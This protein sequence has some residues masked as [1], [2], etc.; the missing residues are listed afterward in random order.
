MLK[1]ISSQC[2]VTLVL[3]LSMFTVACDATSEFGDETI[4]NFNGSFISESSDR[5]GCFEFVFPL[6]LTLSDGTTLDIDSKDALRTTI[7]NVRLES[8]DNAKPDFVFPLSVIVDEETIELATLQELQELKSNCRSSRVTQGGKGNR[9]K[10]TRTQ[11]FSIVYPVSFSFED[12]SSVSVESRDEL[13]EAFRVFKEEN[14]DATERPS[15]VYPI[16]VTLEDGESIEVADEAAYNELIESC[17]E[18]N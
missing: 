16:T 9:V 11:C 10:D 6:Q 12:G 17:T 4:E 5:G 1:L 3:L 14:P 18:N 7:Q 15:K 8:T 2:F 13:R